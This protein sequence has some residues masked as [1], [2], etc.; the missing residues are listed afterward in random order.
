MEKTIRVI[1]VVGKGV[2]YT[3]LGLLVLAIVGFYAFLGWLVTT[4]AYELYGLSWLT[5]V[6]G[7]LWVVVVLL[8]VA[9]LWD[10]WRHPSA[11]R[12]TCMW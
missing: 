12:R 3:A 4:A 5:I 2:G 10:E 7:T 11:Y 8:V 1:G 6:L 9:N